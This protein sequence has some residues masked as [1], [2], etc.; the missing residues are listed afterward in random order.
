MNFP[1]RV[2]IHLSKWWILYALIVVGLVINLIVM[3]RG[4]R[5]ERRVA[6]LANPELVSNN[7]ELIATIGDCKVYQL[8]RQKV[9]R[10]T[11]CETSHVSM[12]T[13]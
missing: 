9:T 13:Y 12:G 10:I 3:E 4:T 7:H 1:E 11:I 2:A 8:L 5:V 6:V